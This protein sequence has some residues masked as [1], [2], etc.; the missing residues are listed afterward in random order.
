MKC[1][2][3]NRWKRMRPVAR[4]VEPPAKGKIISLPQLGR[5]A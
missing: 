1:G 4:E 3:I 5:I 2:R